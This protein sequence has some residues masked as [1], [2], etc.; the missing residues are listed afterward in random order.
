MTKTV[1]FSGLVAAL[2]AVTPALADEASVNRS[3]D[4]L[5]G[6]H[7][8]YEPAIKAFQQA[9]IDGNKQDVA[10]FI[11]Y[12]IPVEIGGRKR[13]IR[14]EA[15]FVKSYDAIMTPAIVAAVKK[16]NYGDLFVRDQGVM[17]GNGEV[18]MNGV[19]TDRHCRHFVVQVLTIQHTGP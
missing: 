3:I 14:S 9:V 7:A 2:L 17:F 5:L 18:W 1:F 8:I 4:Q 16:Q 19:C 15:A 6:S 12:P 10:A 13:S 11:R